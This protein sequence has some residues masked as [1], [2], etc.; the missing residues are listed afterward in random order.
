M[1]AD[2]KVAQKSDGT[3]FADTIQMLWLIYMISV[4]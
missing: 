3:L 2:Y 1:S 4:I